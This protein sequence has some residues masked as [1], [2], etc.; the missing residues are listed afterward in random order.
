M[1]T[2]KT[3]SSATSTSSKLKAPHKI[4]GKEIWVMTW[5]QL[6]MM[7]FQF[8]VGF[9]DVWVAGRIGPD[10]QASLTLVTQCFYFFMII[11]VSMA[12]ASVAGMSQSL[13]AKKP[14]RAKRYLGMVI[15]LGCIFC[16]LTVS[17]GYTGRRGIMF[18]LNVPDD[19]L[20]LVLRLW[21]IFIITLPTQ[22]AAVFSSA[23]FRAHKK[24]YIPLYSAAVVFIV[25]LL[26]D[27]GLGLGRFGLPRL[28]AEGLALATFFASAAGA[29]F[30]IY[31][32][33][34][35]GYL[36]ARSFPPLR[37][38][39]KAIRYFAKVALPAGGMQFS[40]Q[41][42]YMV[43]MSI[44]SAMPLESVNIVAGLGNGM[45]IESIL[46]LPAVAFSMT[47]SVLVG[48]SL[49]AGNKAEAKRVGLRV[50]IA[51]CLCMSVV[52]ALLWPF[53]G[54]IAAQM[55][56]ESIR[57]QEISVSYIKYNLFSTPF[58]IGSM[59]L[60][61]ILTGAGATMYPFIIYSCATWL[62]RLPLAY[63]LGHVYWQSADG[64]FVSMLV[65]QVIQCAV[66]YYIFS[67]CDWTRFALN[68]AKLH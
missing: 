19:I 39:K 2:T 59:V 41:L 8:L 18:L 63:F 32:L 23:A 26:L 6:L 49:G 3:A 38:Y 10:I 24:V 15:M 9:T 56:P 17:I 46:F 67:R 35:L 30:N 36:S 40:W 66:I 57:V 47:G 58:T 29:S 43:L 51:A 37:W 13:G 55:S 5:P 12:N 61:G 7:L 31:M 20:P 33:M 60:G 25:N 48:H 28:E 65:S 62:V 14:W 50:L 11:G 45:K 52:A 54:Y 1:S 34:R 16:F 44:T 53:V 42:G 64:I 27:F 68:A 4:S 22:F 21:A